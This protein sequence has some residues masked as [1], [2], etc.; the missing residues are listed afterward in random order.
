MSADRDREIRTNWKKAKEQQLRSG[1]ATVADR[2][3]A[4]L[5]RQRQRDGVPVTAAQV[6]FAA[7][8]GAIEAAE[9][10]R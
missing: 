2:R 6:Q 10:D 5:I 9:S 3:Q 7:E 4:A 8:V 1:Y